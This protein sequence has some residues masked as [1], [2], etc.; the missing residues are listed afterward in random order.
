MKA[1][2]TS[3]SLLV[4]SGALADTETTDA[5]TAEVF[6]AFDSARLDE[7]TSTTLAPM[8]EFAKAHPGVKIV[9]DGH[10]DPV[11]TAVYNVKLSLRRAEVVRDRLARAGVNENQ[12][13][14]G[15]Y[16]KNGLRRTTHAL[17]RRV[18][19]WTTEEPIRDVVSQTLVRGTAAIWSKPVDATAL[20]PVRATQTAIR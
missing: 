15:V 9:L 12:I 19:I 13:V 14:L 20:A 18:T 2:L 5:P 6:F 16:G 4:T 17:D 1:L 7:T 8:V 3:M 10:T 11:G